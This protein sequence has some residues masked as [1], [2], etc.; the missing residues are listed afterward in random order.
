MRK[1]KPGKVGSKVVKAGK[2]GHQPMV[3]VVPIEEPVGHSEMLEAYQALSGTFQEGER[4]VD[5][6]LVHALWRRQMRERLGFDESSLVAEELGIIGRDI[7]GMVNEETG[8][9]KR[10]DHMDESLAKNI[11]GIKFRYGV[12]GE[13][14]WEYTLEDRGKALERM[15]RMMGM[16]L[17]ESVLRE[18]G[19]EGE[20]GL[21]E[22]LARARRR[23]GLE[24]AQIVGKGEKDQA[25]PSGPAQSL[26]PEETD[27]KKV[28][29]GQP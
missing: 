15:E 10:L 9:M 18:V 27:G 6:P 13:V 4:G 3:K 16:N 1:E 28:P 2:V 19:G 7:R 5:E 12:K 24:E 25:D 23:V 26:P 17:S 20:E 8:H 22:K 11:K 29:E 14:I 21:R